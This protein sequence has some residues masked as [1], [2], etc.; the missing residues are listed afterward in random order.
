MWLL[1]AKQGTT[2]PTS[3]N[4]DQALEEAL[5]HGWID[6]QAR[7]RDEATYQQRFT[8]RRSD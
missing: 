5:C 2:E 3:V 7:R 6:S 4:Y 1:L 8:P